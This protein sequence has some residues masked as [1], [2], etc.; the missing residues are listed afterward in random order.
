MGK[1]KGVEKGKDSL[2][3]VLGRDLGVRM[4]V[5]AFVLWTKAFSTNLTLLVR[6]LSE[7]A[8]SD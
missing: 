6:L 2:D 1:G 3:V 8:D 7:A 5:L 4:R